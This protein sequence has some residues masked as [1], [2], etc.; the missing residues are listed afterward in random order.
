M[1]WYVTYS[2]DIG[3]K[4]KSSNYYKETADNF[5]NVNYDDTDSDDF[6]FQRRKDAISYLGKD[7]IFS[8]KIPDFKV[9]EGQLTMA[10]AWQKCVNNE[11]ESVLVCEAGTGTGKTF[12][13]LIPAILSG[14]TVVISTASKAL[15]D[16]LVKKD[17]P[18]LFDLLQLPPDF[19]SLKGFNN[20]LCKRK[21]YEISEKFV[22]SHALKFE[23]VENENT[24]DEELLYLNGYEGYENLYVSSK[25]KFTKYSGNI[26][27]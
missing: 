10:D 20:Y 8:E 19:M 1:D 7:G 17:L 18:R 12:A 23:E 15:Q 22:N 24:S 6:S 25:I 2:E 16:Q 3:N 13:Y 27:K 4:P 9:R 21:Y 5:T 14:K 26:Y 11:S